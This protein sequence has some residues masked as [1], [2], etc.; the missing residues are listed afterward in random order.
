MIQEV[1]DPEK[2][3]FPSDELPEIT[4]GQESGC[5]KFTVSPD[6]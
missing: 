3:F 2:T 5:R 1:S 4:P 6:R